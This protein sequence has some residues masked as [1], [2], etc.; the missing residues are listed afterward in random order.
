[1]FTG[2]TSVFYKEMYQLGRDRATLVM[3][4]VLPVAQL[5]LYGYAINTNVRN[6]ATAVYDLD[7]RREARDLIAAFEN[8][9]FF[10]I[11]EYVGSD[12]ELN[13]ALVSGRASVGMKILPDYS[14]RLAAGRQAEALVL[15]DGSDPTIATQSVTVSTAVGLDHSL[16]HR[17]VQDALASLDGSRGSPLPVDVRPQMLFNPQSRSANF[18]LPGLVAIILQ[19]ITVLLTSLSIV[20]E[21]ERGTLEQLLVTPIRPAGLMLGKLAPYGIIGFLELCLV[22][23]VMRV[24]F[25]VPIRG[26]VGMLLAVSTLF[27]FCGLA[28]GL[29]VSAHSHNQAQAFQFAWA[30]ILPS[31]LLSGFMFPRVSMPIVMQKLGLLLP[32]THY[33]EII[34]GVVL[35]GATLSDL[36]RQT[37]ALAL[38]GL[39]LF[40]LSAVGFRRKLA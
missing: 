39:L 24:I 15:I 26:G 3:V 27:L 4:L 1:M 28:I 2:F 34:R 40:A 29:F 14:E 5:V 9:G 19:G 33:I 11:T 22:L 21:R 12:E 30:F 20:R 17:V 31:L 8:T 38:I 7:Q 37:C 32:A 23:V 16:A 13:R 36:W 10:R 35:R 25:D 6:V 18:L